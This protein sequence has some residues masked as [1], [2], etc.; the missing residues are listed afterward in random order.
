MNINMTITDMTPEEALL[1]LRD[2]AP[3]MQMSIT[4]NTVEAPIEAAVDLGEADAVEPVV[5][6]PA[7]IP[8]EAALPTHFIEA[9]DS[10]GTDV[11][12]LT[13]AVEAGQPVTDSLGTDVAG[14]P[15]DKRIHSSN[16][17][18]TKKGVWQRRRSVQDFQ[19]NEISEALKSAMPVTIPVDILSQPATLGAAVTSVVVAPTAE[20]VVIPPT[21]AAPIARDFKGF[22]DQLVILFRSGAIDPSYPPTIVDRINKAFEAKINTITDIQHVPEMITFA[23]GCLEIDEHIEKVAA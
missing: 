2:T 11:A 12:D 3:T 17:K 22:S 16:Q 8:E 20:V 1:L 4:P 13:A 14:I 9:I 5:E 10:L 15:W 7:F 23:W 18:K 19:Y 6:V 21:V